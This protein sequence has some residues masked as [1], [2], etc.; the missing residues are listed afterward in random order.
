[1]KPSVTALVAA[2]DSDYENLRE[3]LRELKKS[4]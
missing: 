3:I 4:E 1:M 2:D